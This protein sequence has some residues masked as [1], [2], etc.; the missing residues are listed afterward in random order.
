MSYELYKCT[1]LRGF[2]VWSHVWS[3]VWY[4]KIS[5]L[6]FKDCLHGAIPTAIFYQWKCSPQWRIYIVKFWTC[7]SFG[8]I[9]FIYMQFLGKFWPYNRLASPFGLA[10]VLGNPGSTA[11]SDYI[12]FTTTNGL[13]GIQC[14]CWCGAIATSTLNPAET[15]NHSHNC[16][17]WTT[18]N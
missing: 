6:K 1:G 9:F 5:N 17:M 16:T 8:P 13:Y 7:P 15:I 2:H 12:Y 10:P 18:L 11:N 4:L 3:H 14:Q